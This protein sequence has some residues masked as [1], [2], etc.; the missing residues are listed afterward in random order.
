MPE[1]FLSAGPRRPSLAL[2]L[3]LGL[4]ALAAP[5]SALPDFAGLWV[6]K[7]EDYGN[8]AAFSK[9][10][11][12]SV[13][14][15]ALYGTSRGGERKSVFRALVAG[16]AGDVW[17]IEV[18]SLDEKGK[19]S[20]FQILVSGYERAFAEGSAEAL[21]LEGLRMGGGGGKPTE[22]G[23]GLLAPFAPRV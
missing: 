5:A 19:E 15:Y 3:A 10:L 11:P 9:P 13:G 17:A 2:I 18:W 22:I 16:K 7:G 20:V 4:L 8:P 12:W 23:G 21:K 6:D 1:R 14:Q